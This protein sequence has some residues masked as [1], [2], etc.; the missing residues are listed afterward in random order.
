MA[1]K[2]QLQPGADSKKGVDRGATVGWDPYQVW[3]TRIRPQQHSIQLRATGGVNSKPPSRAMRG[4]RYLQTTLVIAIKM[5]G[6][7]LQSRRN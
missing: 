5:F 2:S 3:L 7:S 4:F 1:D 6:V